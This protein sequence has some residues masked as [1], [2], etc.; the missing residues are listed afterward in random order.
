MNSLTATEVARRFSEVL[1]AVERGKTFRVT[2]AGRTVAT[3]GP[4]T[5]ASGK[6]FKNLLHAHRLDPAWSSEL[7]EL[8]RSLVV[9][10]RP[11]PV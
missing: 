4:T 9:R 11:W 7:G 5:P 3:I 6:A 2:R 8:R 10:E 1:D